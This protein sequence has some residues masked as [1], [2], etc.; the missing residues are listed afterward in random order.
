MRWKE[1]EE[2]G[3]DAVRDENIS[4]SIAPKLFR[5]GIAGRR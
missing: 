5:F 1:E 4:S 3:M 2:D